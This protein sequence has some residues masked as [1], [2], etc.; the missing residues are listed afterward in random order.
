[1]VEAVSGGKLPSVARVSEVTLW[2][3]R[4]VLVYR[5]DEAE[6]A[7]R[8]ALN[9]EPLNDLW[10]LETLLKLPVGRPVPLANLEGRDRRRLSKGWPAGTAEQRGDMVERVATLPLWVDLAVVCSETASLEALH[11]MPFGA[12]APQAIWL[13][14]LSA[15]SEQL[16]EEAARFS[17]GV[18]HWQNA[19]E[20]KV[21]VP[22]QPL[23]DV[24]ITAAGWRFTEHAYEQVSGRVGGPG[25]VSPLRS[26][27]A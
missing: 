14:C 3:V 4:V 9:A 15:G 20:P 11:V 22:V 12:Y 24:T 27:T 25:E 1:M 7:R 16:L 21:L 13:D 2:G 17:T 19:G 26:P 23:A 5:L 18:V 10:L 8:D 6:H